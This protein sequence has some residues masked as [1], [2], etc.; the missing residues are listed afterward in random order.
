MVPN[1]IDKRVSRGIL[2][3][4]LQRED[5]QTCICMVLVLL[6]HVKGMAVAYWLTVA[7]AK[8]YQR[9]ALLEGAARVPGYRSLLSLDT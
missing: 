7:K 4:S 3:G 1:A 2:S 8:C 6:Y 9:R 5:H